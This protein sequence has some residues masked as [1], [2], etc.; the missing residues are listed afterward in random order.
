MKVQIEPKRIDR[1]A[2][3]VETTSFAAAEFIGLYV[4][5]VDEEFGETYWEWVS[6]HTKLD[7]AYARAIQLGDSTPTIRAE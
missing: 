2:N 1:L 4:Q 7:S 5:R 6:D 3:T